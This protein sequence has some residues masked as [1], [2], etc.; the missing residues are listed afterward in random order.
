[1]SS[2]FPKLCLIYADI[3]ECP[4]TTQQIRY[5]PTF[6]FYRDGERVDEMFGAGDE[7]LRDRLW[8]HS[9]GLVKTSSMTREIDWDWSACEVNFSFRF[10]VQNPTTYGEIFCF[11]LLSACY[12]YKDLYQICGFIFELTWAWFIFSTPFC[13]SYWNVSVLN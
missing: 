9:W 11:F 4:E 13:L 10:P 7:R 2:E 8:L 1:M 3:D 5:T 6:C 12:H